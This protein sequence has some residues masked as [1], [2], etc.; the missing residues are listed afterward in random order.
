MVWCDRPWVPAGMRAAPEK[1]YIRACC[2]HP[3]N[4]VPRGADRGERSLAPRPARPRRTGR[5]ARP[6][7]RAPVDNS[8]PRVY[9]PGHKRPPRHRPARVPSAHGSRRG[10]RCP[11]AAPARDNVDTASHPPVLGRLPRR[12]RARAD[13]PAV[14]DLDPAALRSREAGALRLLGAEPLRAA[15]GQGPLRRP[16]P[17]A[18]ARRP[19]G[20][21][22]GAIRRGRRVARDRSGR[23][24]AGGAARNGHAHPACLWK[25]RRRRRA[26]PAPTPVAASARPDPPHH[27]PREH[28]PGGLNPA[29]RSTKFVTGK[30][31]QLARAAGDPGGREPD[32]LQPALRLWR[33][34]ARQDAPDPGDRQPDPAAQPRR[35]DPLHPRRAVR[36]RR[37]ARLPAQE[38]RSTSSATTARSTC[39]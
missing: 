6:S 29:S 34:R 20:R 17:D 9:N 38:L 12:L 3:V 15:V 10:W 32:L 2:R 14:R 30:A 27:R 4:P 24:P 13:A 21:A 7:A 39:C 26:S 33:R 23:R 31:N 1:P 22:A 19:A 28:E 5:N 11:P 37:R 16:H 36:G 25:V 8:P 35:E 18:R